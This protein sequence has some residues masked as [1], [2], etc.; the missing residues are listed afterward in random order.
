VEASS[1][2]IWA[3]RRSFVWSC[4]GGRECSVEKKFKETRLG[5][6]GDASKESSL[7]FFPQGCRGGC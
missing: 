4:L 5:I 7:V 2:L 1:L 3:I 6:W